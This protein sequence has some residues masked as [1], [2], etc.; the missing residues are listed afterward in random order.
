M[1][2]SKNNMITLAHVHVD[3]ATYNIHISMCMTTRNIHIF[4]YNDRR[5]DYGIF[6]CQE[7]ACE[8]INQKLPE[9]PF[10]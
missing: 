6:D 10:R 2:V 3:G 8:F 9:K 7:D 5:C 4:K 1:T